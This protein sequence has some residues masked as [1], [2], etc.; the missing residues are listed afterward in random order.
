MT[1]RGVTAAY[2]GGPVLRKIDLD[3]AAGEIVSLLGPSG[4]G[5]TTLLRVIAGL[6]P[7]QAGRIDFGDRT[8]SSAT[9]SVAPEHRRVG[10]VF[11]DGAL[12]PHLTV[13]ANV[14]FGISREP[15]VDRRVAEVLDLVGL[16]DLAHR[17][18]ATLSGGEQQ[19]VA[20][21]RALAPRPSVLLLDEPFSALDTGLRLQLRRQVRRIL[22][23]VGITVITVTHDQDE[24]FSFGDRVAVMRDGV[25]AQVGRPDELYERPRDCWVA[26]FVGD[27]NLVRGQANGRAA[28][29]LLGPLPLDPSSAVTG[30]A[31]VLVRPEQL[32]LVAGTQAVIEAVE[33]FGHDAIYSL[34]LDGQPIEVRVARSEFD[35]GDRVDVAFVGASVAA[36]PAA[37]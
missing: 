10:M 30:D 20:L 9:A 14:A 8:V 27:A 24:A 22:L 2:D 34:S 18:P 29:T 4:C 3:V 35:V 26:R 23:D 17:R 33:Y 28:T 13:A 16:T 11:Q 5:K 32:R 15:N 12:F 1:L 6:H 36:F 25:I 21:A 31:Q 19:R 37:G 7:I